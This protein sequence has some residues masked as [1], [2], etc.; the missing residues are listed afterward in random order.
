M[1]RALVGVAMSTF[2]VCVAVFGWIVWSHLQPEPY[3]IPQGAHQVQVDQRG[4]TGRYMSYYLPSNMSFHDL[5][6]SI[7][8]RGW[9]RMAGESG[10]RPIRTF[11]RTLFNGGYREIVRVTR[12]TEERALI[13]V[14]LVRC[15]TIGP[16]VT[17]P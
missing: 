16:W 5:R 2:L 8:H 4:I 1:I 9:R 3:L 7:E 17:C 6:R 15:I 13:T 14:E 11:T 12:D 10:R